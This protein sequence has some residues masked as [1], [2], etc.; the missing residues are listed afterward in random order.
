MWGEEEAPSQLKFEV[1]PFTN[2]LV[3]PLGLYLAL[4]LETVPLSIMAAA[5]LEEI[6]LRSKD[7][8]QNAIRRYL[9]SQDAAKE[10]K[11]I[12]FANANREKE[13]NSKNTNRIVLSYY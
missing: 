7:I 1:S 12:N 4:H 8:R 9:E 2:K 11:D 6:A 3:L 5:K 13:S 10:A